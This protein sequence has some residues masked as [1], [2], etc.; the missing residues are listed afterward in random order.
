MRMHVKESV[1][2]YNAVST[3]ALVFAEF[4]E[5]GKADQESFWLLGVNAKNKVL[6]KEML[7]LGGVTSTS[8]DLKILFKRLL[9]AGA[10]GFVCCHSHPSGS[11]EPSDDDI[12]LTGIIKSVAVMLEMRLLDHVI[13]GDGYCS[14]K[15]RGLL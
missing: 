12:R 7:F 13:I 11:P 9:V 10:D 1:K 4:R 5:I 6:L 14:F 8:V 3:P 2:S 15:E